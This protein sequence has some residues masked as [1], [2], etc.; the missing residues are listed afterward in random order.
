M[1][2][3]GACVT[4]QGGMFIDFFSSYVV[5]TIILCNFVVLNVRPFVPKTGVFLQRKLADPFA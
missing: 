3:Y 2:C 5:K 1:G 4:C